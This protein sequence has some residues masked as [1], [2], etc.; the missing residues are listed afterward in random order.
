LEPLLNIFAVITQSV[1]ST[2]NSI[3]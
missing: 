1:N 2:Q 3:L